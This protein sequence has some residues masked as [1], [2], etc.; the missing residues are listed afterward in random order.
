VAGK[1]IFRSVAN[2]GD[3]KFALD[4][5]ADFDITAYLEGLEDTAIIPAVESALKPAGRI[6]AKAITA[7]APSPGYPGD[8][9]NRKPLKESIAY[10]IKSYRSRRK[11]QRG[12]RGKKSG[13]SFLAVG[14][15][16]PEGAHAHLVERG[17]V[18]IARNYIGYVRA[19]PF[20][21]PAAKRVQGKAL[22][23]FQNRLAALRR[24]ALGI[25]KKPKRSRVE[26]NAG[27]FTPI[28]FANGKFRRVRV[29][30]AQMFAASLGKSTSVRFDVH[31]GRF[32]AD[33]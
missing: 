3:V 8:K 31:Q 7:A 20:L 33:D 28:R 6:F 13:I 10:K 26:I 29:S 5:F 19:Y 18:M 2:K 21:Q 27:A 23:A 11:G 24:K 14:G 1:P 9:P 12:R 25:A 30:R 22:T 15:K 32:I 4:Y 17:H 16:W